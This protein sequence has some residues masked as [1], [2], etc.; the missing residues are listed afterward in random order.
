MGDMADWDIEQGFDALAQ[1]EAGMCRDE[2]E[3]CWEKADKW[4]RKQGFF[5]YPV[6]VCA[7]CEAS[8]KGY[9]SKITKQE[10]YF[11]NGTYHFDSSSCEISNSKANE[12]YCDNCDIRWHTET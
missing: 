2:C 6:A 10:W 8:V 4:L 12:F 3:Y 9:P 1:H 7:K 11:Y 5:D